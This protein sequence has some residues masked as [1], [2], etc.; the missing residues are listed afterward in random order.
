MLKL[1]YGLNYLSDDDISSFVVDV[2]GQVAR[3]V[4]L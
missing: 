1:E 2:E 4:A 3:F